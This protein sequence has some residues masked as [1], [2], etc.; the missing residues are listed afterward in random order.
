MIIVIATRLSSYTN[1]SN[2]YKLIPKII[3]Y[4]WFGGAEKPKEVIA[5]ISTWKKYCPDFEI[6]EWNESNFDVH[7]NTYCEQAYE[8]RKWAFVSDVARLYAL[9]EEGGFYLDTD[10]E[11]IKNIS[12][13]TEMQAVVGFEG[14]KY[15]GTNFM[16]CVP[17]HPFFQAF[18]DSYAKR[19]FVS[20]DGSFDLVTNVTEITN[21]FVDNGLERDGK[22][23]EVSGVM[24]YPCDYFS[25]YD[26]IDGQLKKTRNTYSIHWFSQS[27][28]KRNKLKAKLIQLYHRIIGRNVE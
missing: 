7:C 25:P 17:H 14:T 6:K 8:N 27:W 10:V 3:H 24:I 26:Y 18:L 4:C 12:P 20:I 9:V 13:L 11:L 22:M 15:I 21:M 23:Q 5:F 28:I 16:A 1:L 19:K 2:P